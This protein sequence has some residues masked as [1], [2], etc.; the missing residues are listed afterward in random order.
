[1]K[2]RYLSGEKIL[3]L[4]SL[5]LL[6]SCTKKESTIAWKKNITF[7]EI[8]DSAGDKYIMIDFIKYG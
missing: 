4:I 2:F 5:I 8:L 7:A 1:M 3:I 6:I